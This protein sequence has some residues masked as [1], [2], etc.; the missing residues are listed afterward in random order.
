MK[1]YATLSKYLPD[2]EFG[3]EEIIQVSE[4]KTIENVLEQLHIP[5]EDAKII[6]VNRLHQ[7][8]DYE[9]QNN[10]LLVIFPPVGGG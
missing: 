6:F 2:T 3:E 7:T 1:L 9:L 4:G 5:K 8:L 10:D